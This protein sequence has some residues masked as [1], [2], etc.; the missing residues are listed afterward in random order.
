MMFAAT[1]SGVFVVNAK[2]RS[3][4][5]AAAPISAAGN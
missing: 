4:E 3:L 5:D 2:G 1:I